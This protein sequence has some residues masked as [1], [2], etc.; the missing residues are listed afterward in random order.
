M[1]VSKRKHS[2]FCACDLEKNAF[3]A[4]GSNHDFLRVKVKLTAEV[5]ENLLPKMESFITCQSTKFI[6]AQHILGWV[7]NAPNAKI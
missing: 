5:S 6:C 1:L 3:S 4:N 2:H 7:E